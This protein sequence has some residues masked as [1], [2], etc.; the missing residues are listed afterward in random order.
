MAGR[1]LLVAGAARVCGGRE[2][3][4]N[5]TYVQRYVTHEGDARYLGGSR[6]GGGYQGG[7]QCSIRAYTQ[8]ENPVNG[9][10]SHPNFWSRY[11]DPQTQLD[12]QNY[13]W[14]WDGMAWPA[15]HFK[16]AKLRFED[17]AGTWFSYTDQGYR[18]DGV[19]H[20]TGQ[21]WT[22]GSCLME[23]RR[24]CPGDGRK[25]HDLHSGETDVPVQ[26]TDIAFR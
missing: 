4:I 8:W 2:R 23:F 25:Q 20:V 9:L 10:F 5:K 12:G 13:T 1:P 21:G 11:M 19:W 24:T 6:G 18:L 7:Y 15:V 26:D 22:K 17:A 14:W 3:Y 16:S